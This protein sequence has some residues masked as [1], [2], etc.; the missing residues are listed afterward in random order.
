[1]EHVQELLYL[2]GK[3]AH[4]LLHQHMEPGFQGLSGHGGVLAVWGADEDCVH[5]PGGEHLTVV[6]KGGDLEPVPFGYGLDVFLV[7]AA[8]CGELQ[9]LDS[10]TRDEAD[11]VARDDT[12][13][14]NSQSQ[15]RAPHR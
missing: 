5:R 1:M 7:P 12:D 10:P 8:Q 14:G 4:R 6:R 13:P 9:T 3:D 2:V 11:V 15:H